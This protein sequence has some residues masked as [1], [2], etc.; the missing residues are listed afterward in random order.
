METPPKRV[1]PGEVD[2]TSYC[3]PASAPCRPVRPYGLDLSFACPL[4]AFRHKQAC[5]PE[6]QHRRELYAMLYA[7][8]PLRSFVR[9]A[10]LFMDAACESYRHDTLVTAIFS[11]MESLTTI[12]QQEFG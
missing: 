6:L 3:A 9:R 8:C 12:S 5:P 7:P 11:V 4:E 1:L 10:N 2:V